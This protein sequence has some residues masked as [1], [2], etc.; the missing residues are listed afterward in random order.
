MNNE[1]TFNSIPCIDC[2]SNYDFEYRNVCK[3]ICCLCYNTKY[4]NLT[5]DQIIIKRIIK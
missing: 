3:E 5:A 1:K 4:F 2:G